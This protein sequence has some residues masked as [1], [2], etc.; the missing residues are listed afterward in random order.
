MTHTHKLISD[1]LLWTPPYGHAK[2]DDRLE[3]I[4]NN[5]VPIEDMALKYSR[6]RWTIKTGGE[7]GSGRSVLGA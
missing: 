6:E 4:Y 2:Q 5:F 7:R 1:V 3:S